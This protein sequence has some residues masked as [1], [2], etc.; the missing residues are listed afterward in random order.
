M[1]CVLCKSLGNGSCI[2]CSI[3]YAFV[4]NLYCCISLNVHANKLIVVLRLLVGKLFAISFEGKW[5][6]Y[7]FRYAPDGNLD[8]WAFQNENDIFMPLFLTG[9]AEVAA[10][11]NELLINALEK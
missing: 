1:F 7:A 10:Y 8:Q 9:T 2:C 11:V 4:S 3:Y 5:G 6:N